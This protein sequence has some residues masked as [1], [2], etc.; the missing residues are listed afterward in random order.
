MFYNI[1]GSKNV[2]SI[3]YRIAYGFKILYFV[4][5]EIFKIFVVTASTKILTISASFKR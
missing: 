3:V 2:I 4:V 5:S 1:L